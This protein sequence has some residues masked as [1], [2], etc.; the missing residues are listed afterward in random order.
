MFG[1]GDITMVSSVQRV[2]KEPLEP[3][4]YSQM[5]FNNIIKV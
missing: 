5:L 3:Q 4:D 1:S 2:S